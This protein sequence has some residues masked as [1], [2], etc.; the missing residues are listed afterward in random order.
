M[1]KIQVVSWPGA[2][3]ELARLLAM[4]MPVAATPSPQEVTAL[5]KRLA[6]YKQ[7][8]LAVENGA[9]YIPERG[10]S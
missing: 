10:T 2:T 3:E 4:P 8:R 7:H 9:P 1:K 6:Q 5:Y